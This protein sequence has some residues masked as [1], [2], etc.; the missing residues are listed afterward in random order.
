[1]ERQDF[2]LI[3]HL[4]QTVSGRNSETLSLGL[5]DQSGTLVAQTENHLRAW[6]APPDNK[7]TMTSVIV[8]IRLRMARWGQLEVA[9]RPVTEKH[10]V[11]W[12]NH[13]SVM[14]SAIMCSV[15]FLLF[16]LYLRRILQHLN[17]NLAIPARVRTIFD[18]L[19]EGVIAIDEHD[20]IVLANAAFRALDRDSAAELTGNKIS[21][22]DWLVNALGGQPEQWPWHRAMHNK[23]AVTGETITVAREGDSPIKRTVNSAPI[24][25]ERKNVL[26]CLIT[27]DDLSLIEHT[28][29]QLLDMVAQL[30][31]AN[32]QIEER[33][34][35]LKYM[36]DHDQLS[37]A[38]TRR[39]FFER[40]QQQFS[41]GT[42]K[43]AEG[44]CIM[45]D[46]DYFKSIN[47]RYGHLVGDQALQRVA[48]ILRENV[49]DQD[50]VCRYGGEEFCVLVR[51][52]ARHP[53]QLAEKLRFIIETT[54]GQAVIPGESARITASFGL[55][56]FE[57]GGTTLTQLIKQADEALYQ[58]KASGRNRVCRFEPKS[59][60]QGAPLAA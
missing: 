57:Q 52:S 24:M 23:A 14:L 39:A 16:Y 18:V 53:E 17:P 41:I 15:G 46:I 37:G 54:C 34:R 4:L 49:D 60:R 31:V 2:D 44:S 43:R 19:S 35:Q 58:A 3:K 47:D 11:A 5:R 25:D 28:N 21:E 36:A 8:P 32:S 29:Q 33:N 9:Y 26:G 59:S 45:V 27:L 12:V 48:A 51:R 50:L 20:N 55:S 56:T 42:G 13:P 1:M 38:L 10:A 22:V 6:V 7:S 40:G 30:K